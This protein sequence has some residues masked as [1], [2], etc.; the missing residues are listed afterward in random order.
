MTK[1]IPDI[2]EVIIDY[3]RE[4]EDFQRSLE[5]YYGDPDTVFRQEAMDRMPFQVRFHSPYTAQKVLEELSALMA[6]FIDEPDASFPKVL[7]ML[8]RQKQ[9]EYAGEGVA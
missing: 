4:L 7:N 6:P 3:M 8:V 1:P 5:F 2:A 9:V